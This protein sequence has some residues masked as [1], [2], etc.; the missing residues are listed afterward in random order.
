MLLIFIGMRD[1]R[2]Q[3]GVIS[4]SKRFNCGGV[5]V[6]EVRM[7]REREGGESIIKE[8]KKF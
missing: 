2:H 4:K 7:A 8:M 3:K 1:L 5:W 6:T